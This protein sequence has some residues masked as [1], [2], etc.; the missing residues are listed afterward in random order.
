MQWYSKHRVRGAKR[1]W[2]GEAAGL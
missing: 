1:V 2:W